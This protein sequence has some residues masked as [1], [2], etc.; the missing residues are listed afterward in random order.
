MLFVIPT[1]QLVLAMR[2]HQAATFPFCPLLRSNRAL[3]K[4]DKPEPFSKFA[5]VKKLH[6]ILSTNGIKALVLGV[7]VSCSFGKE[8]KGCPS[9][10]EA[11]PNSSAS[12]PPASTRTEEESR[13]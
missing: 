9:C 7:F 5:I 12:Q 1:A 10:F 6:A 3:F 8:N 2:S 4:M 13:R 11:C